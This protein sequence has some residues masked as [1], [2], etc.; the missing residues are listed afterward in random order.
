MH[1]KQRLIGD[2]HDARR[3]STPHPSRLMRLAVLYSTQ[4]RISQHLDIN[5]AG[6]EVAMLGIYTVLF[7]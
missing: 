5:S 1:G 7:V 4:H 2:M 3:G 6:C